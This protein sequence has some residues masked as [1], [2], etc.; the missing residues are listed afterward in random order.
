MEERVEQ[1]EGV[2]EGEGDEE[3]DGEETWVGDVKAKD[4]TF[5]HLMRPSHA[6][7]AV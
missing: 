5:L 1:I 2:E 6:F 3:G 7:A 4:T